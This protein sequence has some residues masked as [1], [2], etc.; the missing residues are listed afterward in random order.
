MAKLSILHFNDA[1]RVNPQKISSHSSETI[2]VTQFAAVV[3]DLRDAWSQESK[4][5]LVMFSGDLFSP[6]V[7]GAVTRGS[8]MVKRS[9]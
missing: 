8:H 5:G 4:E 2:D 1:Y 6:A 7:E 3:E 9:A